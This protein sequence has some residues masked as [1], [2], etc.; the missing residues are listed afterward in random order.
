MQYVGLAD[1]F[2]AKAFR[3]TIV[4]NLEYA[5]PNI[6]C[7]MLQEFFNIVSVDTLPP[8]ETKLVVDRFHSTKR[9]EANPAYGRSP[10][11]AMPLIVD[12]VDQSRSQRSFEERFSALS[13]LIQQRTQIPPPVASERDKTYGS[14]VWP[15]P[16]IDR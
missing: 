16:F 15:Q 2:A 7:V 12:A 1:P 11:P 14:G 13:E 4:G 3:I 5:A 9:A 8:A 6:R 10:A